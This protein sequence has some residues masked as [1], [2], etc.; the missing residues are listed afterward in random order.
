MG[1]PPPLTIGNPPP[2]P[3][4]PYRA[5]Q[6]GLCC[7]GQDVE[8]G[9]GVQ[10]PSSPGENNEAA[11]QGGGGRGSGVG[12]WSHIRASEVRPLEGQLSDEV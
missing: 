4:P 3:P 1:L 12:A 8:A 5:L 6:L 10:A 9:W 2:M 11:S 7:P